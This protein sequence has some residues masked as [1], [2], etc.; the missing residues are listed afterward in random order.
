M[1]EVMR[2]APPEPE[3]QRL[4]REFERLLRASSSWDTAGR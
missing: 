3:P 1:G 4:K 2:R